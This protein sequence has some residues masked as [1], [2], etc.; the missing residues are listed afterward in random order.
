MARTQDPHVEGLVPASGRFRPAPSPPVDPTRLARTRELVA[1]GRGEEPVQPTAVGAPPSPTSAAT[2]VDLAGMGVELS[3]FYGVTTPNPPIARVHVPI[4]AWFGT[5][6]DV[7]TLADLELLEK[8]LKNLAAGP[9]RVNTA[10][11]PGASH[12]YDGHEATIA[13]ML[14]HWVREIDRAP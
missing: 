5:N 14:A 6:G 1:G 2:L 12:M 4:L 7:G 11:I 10:M 3:D 9:S 8:T 13:E